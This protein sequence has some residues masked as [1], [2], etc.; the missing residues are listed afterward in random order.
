[1]KLSIIIVSYKTMHMA[2]TLAASL[3]CESDWEVVVVNNDKIN[4]G[5][6]GGC[7]E[8][9]RHSQ[10]EYLLFLNPDVNIG[11]KDVKRLLMYI[12]THQ[13]VTAIGPQ[14]VG[15]DG[16]VVPSSLGSI[17]FGSAL[18]GLSFLQSIFP[19]NKVAQQFWLTDWDRKTTR[20]V[21]VING[22]CMMV[23]RKDFEQVGGFDESFF[24]YWEEN[25]L[26]NRLKKLGK[27]ILFLSEVSVGHVREQSMRQSP[28]D[29]S[30][31]F[32]RSRSI[33]LRKQ[34]GI[35]GGSFLSA[36][37]WITDEWRLVALFIIA[38][39]PR[40]MR[41]DTVPIIDDVRRDYSQAITM[42]EGK[43][44]PLLGIPSSV[45]RFS[46]GPFNVWFDALAFT[47]GGV[48]MF[49][50]VILAGLLTS[51]G[52]VLVY[53]FLQKKVGKNIAFVSS[54]LVAFSPAAISQSRMPFYLFAIPVFVVFFLHAVNRMKARNHRSIFVAVLSFCLLFQWE[55]ALIPFIAVLGYAFFKNRIYVHKEWKYIVAALGLGLFPQILFDISHR[56]QQLC[57]FVVWMGYR[58]VAVSGVDGRHGLTIFSSDFWTRTLT[59]MERVVGGGKVGVAIVVGLS[60]VGLLLA[61]VRKSALPS[62]YVYTLIAT[63]ALFFGLVIHGEPSEAYFPP[64]IVLIP[65]LF[66]FSIHQLL[67]VGKRII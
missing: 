49:S 40:L 25:D 26:C 66:S 22:A 12:Q 14:F 16:S 65:I 9:A 6:G 27:K 59:Q 19:K 8:G 33:Y 4:R 44:I 34:C 13:D 32:R 61:R 1:M 10:G 39:I 41:L 11:C 58:T 35:L 21:G 29:T 15:P 23:R 42:I 50:P 62:W 63:A 2:R 53:T 57:Y 18:I 64:F 60:I 56:C 20:E 67:Q 31:F 55:L 5:F 17:T 45:P 38:S 37:L 43:S 52:V 51:L 28:V 47:L 46:Q 3:S 48:N 54:L 24:L 36:W 7:N 30:T